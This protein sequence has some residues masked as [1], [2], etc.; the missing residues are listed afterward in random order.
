MIYE[1][2]GEVVTEEVLKQK[3]SDEVDKELLILMLLQ[4]IFSRTMKML[5]LLTNLTL[6]I[7]ISL[8]IGQT[9]LLKK[10]YLVIFNLLIL[11]SLDIIQ[12]KN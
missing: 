1:F 3:I 11:M 9:R 12:K 7:L 2:N 5:I 6:I 4:A 8:T 10:Q